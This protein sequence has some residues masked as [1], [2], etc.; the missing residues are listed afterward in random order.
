[1]PCCFDQITIDQIT[2]DPYARGQM[3]C[4]LDRVPTTSYRVVA[5]YLFMHVS[6]LSEFIQSDVPSNTF[7][8]IPNEFGTVFERLE[9]LEIQHSQPERLALHSLCVS[10][11]LQSALYK[12]KFYHFSPQNNGAHVKVMQQ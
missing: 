5:V 1:M 2:I 6:K 11:S 9:E 8:L 4:I 7:L 12:H 3:K 10:L